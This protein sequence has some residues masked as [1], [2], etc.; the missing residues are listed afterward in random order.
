[1]PDGMFL[2]VSIS[3]SMIKKDTVQTTI[4]VDG[5]QGINQLGKLEMKASE[6]RQEIKR[7]K[8][9]TDE[10]VAAN[11][12]LRQVKSQIEQVRQQ[13][14]IT[15]MTM[16]QLTRYQRELSNQIRN[17]TT[18]GTTAYKRLNSELVKV[19]TQIKKQ[20]MEMRGLN[21]FWS[22]LSR[23]VKGFGVMALGYLGI[24]TL[25]QQLNNLIGRSAIY[26]DTLASVMKTTGLSAK[27]TQMLNEALKK[28]DTRTARKE[29]LSMAKVAGKLGIT[30]LRDV[31]GFVR[32]FDKI[33]VALGEDLGNPYS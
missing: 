17:T 19:N 2:F 12:K 26:S 28:I 5:K 3:Q 18:R 22:K 25:T 20:R 10:Y 11:K 1:M 16:Q 29:L 31:E 33:N 4:L 13:I 21:T 24:T 8:K 27:E 15:G 9:G 30:A 6:L 7:A 23:S 32:A 14:G